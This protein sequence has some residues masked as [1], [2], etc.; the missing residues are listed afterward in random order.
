M[1]TAHYVLRFVCYALIGYAQENTLQAYEYYQTPAEAQNAATQKQHEI[2]E[3]AACM[4]RSVERN[5]YLQKES[6]KLVAQIDKLVKEKKQALEDLRLGLY[7][8]K[9]GRTPTEIL[10]QEKIP[11]EAH[12]T[13]V[14]ATRKSASPDR[15]HKK[16]AEFDRKITEQENHLAELKKMHS[17]IQAQYDECWYKKRQAVF[18]YYGAVFWSRFL[19]DEKRAGSLKAAARPKEMVP[20]N[21][22]LAGQV[23]SSP[24]NAIRVKVEGK[25][26]HT[27][28]E[29]VSFAD[30]VESVKQ[31]LGVDRK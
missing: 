7:C 20:A 4:N 2:D 3:S 6:D 1:N 23:I 5:D 17:T 27:L 13:K 22:G 11:F 30:N 18:D 9:C 16:A 8:S 19:A 15:I 25:E 31:H 28:K 29:P 26:V 21:F 10:A 24:L 12:L 14:N